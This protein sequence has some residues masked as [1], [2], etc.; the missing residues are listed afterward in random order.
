MKFGLHFTLGFVA[1][2][3]RFNGMIFLEIYSFMNYYILIKKLQTSVVALIIVGDPQV[4]SLAQH[5]L[6]PQ[7]LDIDTLLKYLKGP[8]TT[9]NCPVHLGQVRETYQST[10]GQP[11]SGEA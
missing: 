3:R 7:D 8:S 6:A 9:P 5:P 10:T 2:P 1:N 4:P 11:A